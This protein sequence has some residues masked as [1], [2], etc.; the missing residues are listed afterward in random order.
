M[1]IKTICPIYFSPTKTTRNVLLA[2][3]HAIQAP[4]TEQIDLTLSDSDILV[5]REFSN[6]LAIIGSPVYAGRLPAVMLSRFKQIKG[7]GRP[8]VIVVV[9]GNR[10][11]EDALIELRD[12]ARA[13][14]F[15]PIAAGAFIGEHSY[16]TDTMPIAANRPDA[17]DLA[18]A[19][20]FGREVRDRIIAASKRQD[21]LYVPGNYPYK[22]MR[23]LSGIAP[24]TNESLCTDCRNCV[25]VCPVAAIIKDNPLE[26]AAD[27]CI[28]CCA[29]IKVCP[30]KAKMFDDPRIRDAAKMLHATF[31]A[32]KEPEFYW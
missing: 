30:S 27:V 9:Y 13:A 21:E 28:R 25:P 3:A 32:R 7:H 16:S 6:D 17:D 23:M 29:C 24:V 31:S 11:Y 14:G 22:E 19:E 2:I 5:C 1:N 12:T 8:A 10:A 20:E 15:N 18:Q 4:L 26:T